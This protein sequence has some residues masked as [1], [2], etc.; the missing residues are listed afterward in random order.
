MASLQAHI[1][2]WIIPWRVKR[3]MKDCRDH[4]LAR[5]IFLPAPYRVPETMRIT[6]TEV[7]GIPG[8]W[9]ESQGSAQ[10]VLL[11]LH[12]GGYFGCSA[13]THHPSPHGL[14]CTVSVSSR[15]TT[16]SPPSISRLRWTTLLPFIA[17][18]ARLYLGN[19]D[20]RNPFASPPYA[21]LDGLPPLLIH[22]GA[23]ETLR[24]DSTRLAGRARAAG[25]FGGT[26][27]LAS[28]SPRVAARAAQ[29]P[30]RSPI[31]AGN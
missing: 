11:Y 19:A 10:S 21:D 7:D 1:A 8:E 20:P 5:Q 2:V 14:P 15:L 12:G 25:V 18:T 17:P 9:V 28:G 6:K 13:E 24:D 26:K 30:R 3:C 27:S 16:A 29:N 22:V 31:L 4:R 23:D